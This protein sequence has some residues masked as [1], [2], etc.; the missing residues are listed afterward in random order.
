[1]M[2]E[3][4]ESA[5]IKPKNNEKSMLSF[6]EKKNEILDSHEQQEMFGFTFQTPLV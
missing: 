3:T 5:D 4:D 1:M 2:N 6:K